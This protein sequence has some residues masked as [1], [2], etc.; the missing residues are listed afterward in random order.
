M[1]WLKKI[2]GWLFRIGLAVVLFILLTEVA[3]RY[4]WFD[5][6]QA[7]FKALNTPEQ[8]EDRPGPT[9]L[10]GGDS[11]TGVQHSY[12]E[13]M[14]EERPNARIINTGIPGTGITEAACFLPDRIAE[15]QPDVFIYQVY[16]G[17]DLLDIRHPSGSSNIGTARAVYWWL[18]DRLRV[19]RYINYKMAQFRY[20][21]TS[22]VGNAESVLNEEFSVDSYSARERLNFAAEPELVYNSAFLKGGREDDFEVMVAELTTVFEQLPDSCDGY[23]LLIPHCAQVDEVYLKRMALLGAEFPNGS[24][25]LTTGYPLAVELKNRLEQ[26]SVAELL[27]A[28]QPLQGLEARGQAA[29]YS[30]DPHLHPEAHAYLGSILAWLIEE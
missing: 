11:F 10:V 20:Q 13:A 1:R 23:V 6:Y 3:F 7:E 16:V 19:L 12:V 8:L 22:E 27:S 28:M 29:Y 5:F 15:W 30:D 26:D 4:Y 2:L 25:M 17:N 14:R 18:A 24:E 9:V 21:F